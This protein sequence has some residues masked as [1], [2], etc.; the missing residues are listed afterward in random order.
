MANQ[1][2]LMEDALQRL[3]AF[4][5]LICATKKHVSSTSVSRNVYEGL[6]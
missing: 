4:F 2:F 5:T 1:D 6:A 3:G